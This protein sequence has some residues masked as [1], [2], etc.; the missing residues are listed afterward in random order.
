MLRFLDVGFM[1][2]FIRG[3]TLALV[4]GVCLVATGVAQDDGRPERFRGGGPRGFQRGPGGPPPFQRDF[5]WPTE[6]T[7]TAG[8]LFVDGE[9]VAPPYEI[10][11]TP[12]GLT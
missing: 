2:V 11:N 3:L 8:F 7:A 1:P 4:T 9:Y 10:R 12:E 5:E 6:I